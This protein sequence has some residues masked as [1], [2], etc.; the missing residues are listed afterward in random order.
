[1]K[2]MAS[3]FDFNGI[4]KL[5]RER[6]LY[7]GSV[8]GMRVGSENHCFVFL[9]IDISELIQITGTWERSILKW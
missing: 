4:E 3:I 2:S 8:E 1:M 7:Q 6:N 5:E 9:F